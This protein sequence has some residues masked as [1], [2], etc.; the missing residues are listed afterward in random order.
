[1]VVVV[2]NVETTI[3]ARLLENPEEKRLLCCFCEIMPL[4]LFDKTLKVNP[5][6]RKR[7]KYLFNSKKVK[8]ESAFM[9]VVTKDH[10]SLALGIVSVERLM[11]GKKNPES[12]D[13][14]F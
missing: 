12:Q 8:I 11:K 6:S 3:T 7:F 2:E 9:E 1:M 14:G 10:Q 13:P 4:S 5:N